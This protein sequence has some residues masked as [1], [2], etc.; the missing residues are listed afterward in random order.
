MKG[1]SIIIATKDRC[2]FLVECV[3]SIVSNHEKINFNF[4]ITIMDQS[5]SACIL[6]KN[7]NIKYV[8]TEFVGKT[9][10]LN[11]AVNNANYEYIGIIDDDCLVEDDWISKMFN[12]I[13]NLKSKEIVTGRVVAGKIED[14]AEKSVLNDNLNKEVYYSKKIITPIFILSGCNFGFK[15]KDFNIIGK[16]DESFGPGAKYKS[17]D[18]N[19]WSYRALHDFG[20][21]LKYSPYLM[22]IHRSWRKKEEQNVQFSDYGLS[23]GVFFAYM[24]RKSVL[25]FVAH[26]IKLFY[27]TIKVC[28]IGT[29]KQRKWQNVYMLEFFKG[30]KLYEKKR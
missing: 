11:K 4:E 22:V 26:I 10:A 23:S 8:N 27:W 9:K 18:D 6:N 21:T 5:D 19:E 14:D 28:I 2:N 16:F 20:Y 12:E 29:R 3:S 24:L 30:F 17:S 7:E 13:D 1:L 25:D 15:K